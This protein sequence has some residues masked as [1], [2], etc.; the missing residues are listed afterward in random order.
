M[1]DFRFDTPRKGNANVRSL[2]G[3]AVCLCTAACGPS[4]ADD[5]QPPANPAAIAAP[6]AAEPDDVA[7][8][9]QP[10]AADISGAN[11]LVDLLEQDIPYGEGPNGNL[12][13]F[14]AVPA[15]AAEPLPGVIVLHEWW[16]LTPEIRDAA[17][18]I[19]RAGYIVL[20]MDLYGG[21]TADDVAGAQELLRELVGQ[22]DSVRDNVRQ[23]Y[24]YVERYA[25][26]PRIGV[27]GWDLG[28]RWALQ[29]SLMYPQD[30]DAVAVIY[31]AI[32]TDET[33]LSTLRM[34][35]LG[36]FAENDASI[37][38][39]DVRGFRATLIRLGTGGEV[40]IYSGAEHGFFF[41]SSGNY[42]PLMAD[43]AWTRLLRYLAAALQQ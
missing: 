31:G 7:P 26:A 30:I 18:R 25:L 28:G 15:D 36:L 37:P 42:S 35:V 1:L 34:P 19:A 11:V 24:E 27:V 14:L 12:V 9:G 3:I 13:G 21:R 39:E 2:L 10:A 43:D 17:R 20:A 40:R 4:P 33:L 8:D 29:A 16:G 38:L 6:V 32:E 5:V 23:A 22:P 41:P